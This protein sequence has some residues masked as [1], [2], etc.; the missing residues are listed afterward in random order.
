[1]P[2]H[3]PE[4]KWLVSTAWL[5]EHIDAP[6][7]IVVDASWHLPGTARD[8]HAEYLERR[9]PGA[10][11][12]DIDA[13]CDRDSALPHMMPPPAQFASQVRALGIGDGM[14]VVIYDALGHF[15]APRVWW[16]FRVMGCDDVAVLD[17]GLPKWISENRDIETGPPRQRTQ[18]HFTAR[19]R[20]EMMRNANEVMTHQSSKNAT[21][22]DARPAPRFSGAAAEPRAGLRA[23]HMPGACNLPAS[24]F[25][26]PDGTF[27]DTEALKAAFEDAG[28]DLASPVVTTCG[29]G[30]TAAILSLGLAELDHEDNALYDGSWTEWGA[31]DDLPVETGP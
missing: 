10:V 9:I 31:R 24:T 25:T 21:V 2:P 18:R 8:G 20:P 6:D 27:L 11:F 14:R 23:G 7:V 12:F 17:G 22:L 28:V 29:S 4:R 19:H 15:S 16:T 5:A 3:S 26:G 13:I 30:V 1:M